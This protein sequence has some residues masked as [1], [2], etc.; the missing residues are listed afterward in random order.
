MCGATGVDYQQD[1]LPGSGESDK[2]LH[3]CSDKVLIISDGLQQNLRLFQWKSV[4]WKDVNFRKYPSHTRQGTQK[5]LHSSSSNFA[6]IIH[7]SK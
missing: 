3:S 2:K 6:L 7:R 1:P 4:K 5:K